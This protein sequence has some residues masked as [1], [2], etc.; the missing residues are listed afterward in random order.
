MSSASQD[1]RTG[2]GARA[3][4]GRQRNDHLADGPGD[5]LSLLQ[6]IQNT[7]GRC[8]KDEA[9]ARTAFEAAIRSGERAVELLRDN[10]DFEEMAIAQFNI[11]FARYELGDLDG[12]LR[13]L[14]Q[15]LAWDQEFGFR[16]ELETDYATWLRWRN[17]EEPDPDE[18]D[19]FVTSFN[20]TKA[21]FQFV[22]QPHRSHWSTEASR[23]NLKSGAFTEVTTRYETK[24]DVRRDGKDWVLATTLDAVPTLQSNGALGAAGATDQLQSLIGSLTAALPEMVIAA[25]GS[26]KSLRNL[27]QHRANLLNEVKRMLAAEPQGAVAASAAEAERAIATILS[28]EL[29]TTLAEGQWDI[30]VGAWIGGEFDHGDWYTLTFAEPL[31]G[32]T[33]Q[34]VSK[35]MNFKV[36]RWLPCAPGREPECVEVLVKITPDVAA[37]SDAI[38]GF[39]ARVMPAASQAELK[40]ALLNVD[41]EFDLRYR[42]VTR[43]RHAAALVAGGTEV[44]L[45]VVAGG[46]QASRV[47]RG[48]SERWRRVATPIDALAERVRFELTSPVKGC[49]FSRP[50]HST[51]LP[52]LRCFAPGRNFG[53]GAAEPQGKASPEQ[54]RYTVQAPGTGRPEAAQME[55]NPIAIPRTARDARIRPL[56]QQGAAKHVS[57]AR[58]RRSL[59]ARSMCGLS[60]AL[61]LPYPGHRW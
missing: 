11:A 5:A 61:N 4:R 8:A 10:W 49:R 45:R 9:A 32:F 16:D 27:E 7:Q 58:R 38:A 44:H 60:L 21:R 12:A 13:D 22:W 47:R 33:D 36:S 39:V 54:F 17:G 28:P 6:T 3:R 37:M 31:P 43:S 59:S 19:R 40:E 56:D 51:A 1:R 55:R 30:A 46:R 15:V 23:A 53:P 2:V 24:V 41:Y 50:V 42:L 20:Q 48:A 26:F 57:A 29:L 52:P 25:D 35:T 14:D 34:P 18:V